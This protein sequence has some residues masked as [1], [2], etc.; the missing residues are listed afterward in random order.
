MAQRNVKRARVGVSGDG[1]GAGPTAAARPHRHLRL[2]NYE[3]VALMLQ[4]GGALGAYQAG[5]F[6]G[7]YEAG[8]EPDWIAGISIGALNTAVIA[9]NP[10]EKRVERLLQ[11]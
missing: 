10:P 3:T 1:E 9:G 7:L 11:F 4:G 6:Q 5:V 2:P 8:I